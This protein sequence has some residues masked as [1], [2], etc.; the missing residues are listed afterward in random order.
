[1][2]SEE[3]ASFFLRQ[4]GIGR[5]PRRLG[6]LQPWMKPYSHIIAVTGSTGGS[7]TLAL[8]QLDEMI[9]MEGYKSLHTLAK[10]LKHSEIKENL[11]SVSTLCASPSVGR[12][13]F[14][15]DSATVF[16]VNGNALLRARHEGGVYVVETSSESST[17]FAFW[18]AV[19]F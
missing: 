7:Y 5:E 8:Q 3:K 9:A 19:R 15:R 13:E 6:E 10:V 12:V 16:A 4:E 14:T 17:N 2:L 18:E 1:M 11:L